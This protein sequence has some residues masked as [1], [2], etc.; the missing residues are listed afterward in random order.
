MYSDIVIISSYLLILNIKFYSQ[1]WARTLAVC[2]SA[3]LV[4][5]EHHVR[6][7]S[8]AEHPAPPSVYASIP[9][10]YVI[11]GSP[12]YSYA[13]LVSYYSRPLDC[14]IN[15][16]MAEAQKGFAVLEEVDK[17]TFKRFVEWAYKGYSYYAKGSIHRPFYIKKSTFQ[18]WI[19]TFP[20]KQYILKLFF[21]I[22]LYINNL[23]LIETFL[24]IYKMSWIRR[25]KK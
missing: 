5:L 25:F 22:D 19:K 3:K 11:E 4:L 16:Q 12:Y 14:I 10:K 7:Q 15:G 23:F 13:D 17:G 24:I 9:F 8:K 18:V 2:S 6:H 20:F 21:L 1:F